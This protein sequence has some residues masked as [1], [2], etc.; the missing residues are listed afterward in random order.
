[1]QS[2]EGEESVVRELYA[3]IKA[4]VRH[5]S[6]FTLIDQ[7]IE[8]REF[9]EWSIAFH[10]LDDS[11]IP[12]LPDFSDFLRTPANSST[13]V[14]SESRARQLLN[15]FKALTKSLP[16]SFSQNQIPVPTP[17]FDERRLQALHKYGRIILNT[18]T[19]VGQTVFRVQ[20]PIG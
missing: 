12:A 11:P 9:P 13:L 7:P 4:D 16:E 2:L 15:C 20:L 17:A 19:E 18:N 6:V 1:M 5:T 8:E 14:P 10:D 3:R